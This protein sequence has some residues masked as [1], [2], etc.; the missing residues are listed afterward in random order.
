MQ[1]I[2]RS[3]QNL[4]ISGIGQQVTGQL[5]E[6]E[7]VPGKVVVEG[8]DHP[9]PPG[10][11]RRPWPV[12]LKAIA[13]GIAGQVHPVSCHPLTIAGAGQQPF[14]QLFIGV[15]RRIS[16][17]RF[18]LGWGWGQ[19]GQIETGPADQ[20][21]PVGLGLKGKIMLL[22]PPAHDR[23]DRVKFN[24]AGLRPSRWVEGPVGL[25]CCPFFD[26]SAEQA[27]LLS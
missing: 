5:P 15:G 4:F 19:A 24:W 3:G 22:E 21:R 27:H 25:V 8:I 6:G 9:V 14:E 26:P 16:S 18:N 12:H 11:H 13:V 7:I 10:P 1:P 20:C 2:E 17:K 23:V